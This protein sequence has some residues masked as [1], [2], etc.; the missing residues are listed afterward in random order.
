MITRS[1]M[2]QPKMIRTNE[3]GLS[4]GRETDRHQNGRRRI[5]PVRALQPT[6]ALHSREQGEGKSS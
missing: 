2:S 3:W 5:I 1:A 4:R 6:M